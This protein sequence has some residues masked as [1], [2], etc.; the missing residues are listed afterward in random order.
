[1]RRAG[2][3]EPVPGPRLRTLGMAA[4]RLLLRAARH[5][6]RVRPAAVAAAALPPGR[7]SL[8]PF[9]ARVRWLFDTDWPDAPL[10]LPAVRLSDGA[11]VI[12]GRGDAPP[13]DVGTAVAASCAVPAWFTPVDIG[14]VGHVDGGVHSPTNADLLAGTGVRV[15]VV[16]SPMSVSRGHYRPAPDFLTRVALGRRLGAEVAALEHDGAGV[17]VLQPTAADIAAM[18]ANAMDPRR[19]RMVLDQAYRSAVGRFTREGWQERLLP[20]QAQ[21]DGAGL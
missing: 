21:R 17:I 7:V 9:A 18:G 14:G 15:V 3:A 20:L 5:P 8:R 10:W 12:F 11:R 16:S 13:V 4:P 2:P 6:S 1:M 19:R